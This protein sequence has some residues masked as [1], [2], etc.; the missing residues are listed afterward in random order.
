MDHHGL[1]FRQGTRGQKTFHRVRVDRVARQRIDAGLI[2]LEA[3]D[4]TGFARAKKDGAQAPWQCCEHG[5]RAV[6]S[7]VVVGGT[8]T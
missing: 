1:R 8:C 6:G 7:E 4:E 3:Q 2:D 5:P